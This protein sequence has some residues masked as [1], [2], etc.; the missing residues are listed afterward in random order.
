MTRTTTLA[1]QGQYS[2]ANFVKPGM[3]RLSFHEEPFAI[4]KPP[5]F[6]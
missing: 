5:K 2:F 1:T 3:R 4:H 6:P